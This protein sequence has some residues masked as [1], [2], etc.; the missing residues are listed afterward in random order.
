M[1]RDAIAFAKSIGYVNAAIQELN[2][3]DADRG[4]Y[5]LLE[6]RLYE[7]IWQRTLA[8]QMSDA[9]GT[10]VSV[11]LAGTSVAGEARRVRDLRPHDHLPRV[12]A[13]L[14][15]GRRRF[16][17]VRQDDSEKRLPQ[18]DPRRRSRSARAGA[19]RALDQPARPLHRG[20]AGQGHGRT[21]H[22]PALH[23]RLDHAD[24]PGPRLRLEEG[25]SAGPDLGGV[26]GHRAARGLLRRL[27]DYGFT[28]SV[29]NDLDSIASGEPPAWTGCA[30]S[31]SELPTPN[32]HAADETRI[33]AQGGLK[34]L[35]AERLEEIDAR[36][37][38]SIQL[39]GPD[40]DVMVRVG[41]YG[42]YLQQGGAEAERRASL[43]EDLAPDELTPEKVE[44]LLSAPSGATASSASTRRRPRDHRQD[45]S[46]RPVRHR[47]RADGVAVQVDVA[48]HRDP[49]R[50]RSELLTLPRV[51]GHELDGEDVTAQN[52]RYGPVHQAG[53][54]S[55]SIESE[56]QLFT[57][58]LDEALAILAQPKQRGRRAAA[59][60]PLKELGVDPVSGR[61]RW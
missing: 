7:L 33:S 14:R 56:E 46:L 16:G 38:N 5:V 10:T 34:K 49:G 27:V 28:A 19:V 12:P 24:D 48:G 45:R 57:V 6:F 44:E 18:L 22:R 26:R 61:S 59:A 51:L 8:S 4:H 9:V 55:R 1:Y 25:S 31:T 42:P 15:R 20:F 3:A 39:F 29:E 36:G 47:R 23:L 41:R 30:S 2:E 60:P 53:T 40:S 17:R 54:D 52:G 50:R 13:R 58:T 37:V 43:P 32:A 21:R 35:I 11:R